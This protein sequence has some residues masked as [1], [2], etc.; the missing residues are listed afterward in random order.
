MTFDG[1]EVLDPTNQ[2]QR[3]HLHLLALGGRIL[4]FK[5]PSD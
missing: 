3:C 1:Q 2:Q 5:L 4:L